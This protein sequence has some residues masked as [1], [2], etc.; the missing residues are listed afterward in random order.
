MS[1]L[2]HP[3][4]IDNVQLLS[5][6]RINNV[7]FMP[8]LPL[9]EIVKAL[10]NVYAY[11]SALGEQHVKRVTWLQGFLACIVLGSAGS[12]TVAVIRGE[13]LGV[14]YKDEFWILY[15]IVYWLMF[16]NEFMH[17]LI[18]RLFLAFPLVHRLCICLSG[19][20][21]GY[22]LVQYGI[23]GVAKSAGIDAMVGRLLCGTIVGCGAGFWFELF[24]LGQHEWKLITPKSFLSPSANVKISFWT[25]VGYLTFSSYLSNDHEAHAMGSLA[26]ALLLVLNH[27]YTSH[28][29]R[30][31]QRVKEGKAD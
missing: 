10:L 31:A 27:Y 5:D 3:S 20:N 8:A 17:L 4:L 7:P 19:I 24:S 29:C 14:I 26:F 13:P 30:D 2:L 11:R 6:M 9:T 18:H 22:S 1:I 21:R 25:S 23:D 12:C 15:G 28:K 16:S